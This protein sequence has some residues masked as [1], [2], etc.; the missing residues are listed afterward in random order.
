MFLIVFLIFL[1][2][3][4]SYQRGSFYKFLPFI[5][6]KAYM[7][8]LIIENITNM[9]SNLKQS[10]L[11]SLSSNQKKIQEKSLE[12]Q[13]YEMPIENIEAERLRKTFLRICGDK[14]NNAKSGDKESFNKKPYLCLYLVSPLI[15]KM[16][17]ESWLSWASLTISRRSSSGFGKWM[18]IWMGKSMNMNL[19]WCIRDAFSIRL[20][21]SLVTFS[22]LSNFWCTTS[23]AEI[24]SQSKTLLSWFMSEI[25]MLICCSNT[26]LRFLETVKR[27]RMGNSARFCSMSTW[28]RCE[29]MICRGEKS[30]K[31]SA[32]LWLRWSERRK[33]LIDC[34]L[35]HL[36]RY[37]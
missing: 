35:R 27:L 26:F 2:V 8:K 15:R 25:L 13:V 3:V 17:L 6:F 12:E 28:N 32:K 16:S 11:T 33:R 19:P 14:V 1:N 31:K 7:H 30:W 23:P 29:R 5:E 20:G 4:A 24:K 36:I 34:S 18:R 9:T 10:N 22:I 37:F 21:S